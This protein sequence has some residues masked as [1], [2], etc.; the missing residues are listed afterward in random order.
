MANIHRFIEPVLLYLLHQTGGSYGYELLTLLDEHA[1]TDA[2]IEGA[3]L[4]RT[5]QRL[6]ENGR[7][8]SEWHAAGSGPARHKYKLTDS[9]EE[10]LNEWITALDQLSQSM[11]VFV[12]KAKANTPLNGTENRV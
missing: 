5:L 4:Y 7:V 11:A 8:S 3:S 9:G 6:E 2:S 10:H 12:E 1:L